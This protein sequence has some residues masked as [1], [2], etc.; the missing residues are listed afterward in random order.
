MNPAPIDQRLPVTV[1]GGYLGAGKTTFINQLL[2][3]AQGRRLAVLVNDFGDVTIDADL[4]ES[5]NDQVMQL[6]GG[7]VCCS[8]G[9]DLVAA[10]SGLSE[11][12]G[13]VDQVLLETSGVAMP[14]VVAA[15][16]ALAPDVRCDAVLVLADALNAGRG[17]RDTYVG[18]TLARQFGA[19]DL[20]LL[21][22]TALSEPAELDSLRA[23]LAGLAPGVAQ[24]IADADL[25]MDL[26]L[27]SGVA[28]N[29]TSPV[30]GVAGRRLSGSGA[31]ATD[32]K[33]EQRL[34]P[35]DGRYPGFVSTTYSTS[36]QID[37]EALR[38]V[39][40]DP[41]AN[42]LRA[43]GVLTGLDGQHHL[44][45][46]VGRRTQVGRFDAAGSSTLNRLLIITAVGA[47][48]PASLSDSLTALGLAPGGDL[49]VGR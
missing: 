38:R 44:V 15:T 16:V 25:P 8:I 23:T 17:L 19:A 46:T 9:S 11:R 41:N 45:Q 6:A 40:M 26:L 14:G 5:V 42:V 39:L 3:R 33:R 35:I 18:D 48:M 24:L 31:L 30:P 49:R 10:L 12:F 2:R 47:P 27:D 28:R 7:C 29:T 36:E 34:R 43:K 1:I 37:I 13:D 20:I 21:T 22:K 32:P 4:I